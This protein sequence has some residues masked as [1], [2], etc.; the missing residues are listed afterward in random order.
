MTNSRYLLFK[1]EI[2]SVLNLKKGQGKCSYFQDKEQIF[3]K[4]A[5]ILRISNTCPE[6]LSF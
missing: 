6:W 2:L 4:E 5:N 3:N 1:M